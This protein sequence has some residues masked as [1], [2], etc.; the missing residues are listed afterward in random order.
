MCPGGRLQSENKRPVWSHPKRENTP[1]NS[2]EAEKKYG[3]GY[4]DCPDYDGSNDGFFLKTRTQLHFAHLGDCPLWPYQLLPGYLFNRC[5]SLALRQQSSASV[6]AKS[7]AGTGPIEGMG[8]RGDHLYAW[9]PPRAWSHLLIA[10]PLVLAAC[11]AT[12]R[13]MASLRTVY[14]N[15]IN[16]LRDVSSKVAIF[17]YRR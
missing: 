16:R 4:D 6:G 7:M 3:D 17:T 2:D 1:E 13:L 11:C 9:H 12:V 10:N 8:R 5:R 14:V 15:D